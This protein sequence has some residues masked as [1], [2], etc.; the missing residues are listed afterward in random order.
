MAKVNHVVSIFPPQ[1]ELNCGWRNF[2]TFKNYPLGKSYEIQE[3][4]TRTV[5]NGSGIFVQIDEFHFSGVVSGT[6][7]DEHWGPSRTG[8]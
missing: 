5:W 3:L 6:G 8:L 1:K 7:P 4:S 2:K